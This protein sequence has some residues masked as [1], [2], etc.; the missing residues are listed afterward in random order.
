MSTRTEGLAATAAGRATFR[1]MSALPALPARL[2]STDA[3]ARTASSGP[4]AA[5][6]P[7]YFSALPAPA[8]VRSAHTAVSLAD[9]VR[10]AIGVRDARDLRA[11]AFDAENVRARRGS[12]KTGEAAVEQRA[13]ASSL[14]RNDVLRR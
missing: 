3:T 13:Q 5:A 7:A 2:R 14:L 6:S 12:Q 11:P 8:A 4:P 10:R 9:E 1:G